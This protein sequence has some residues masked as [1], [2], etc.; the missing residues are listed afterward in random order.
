M[1]YFINFPE[2]INLANEKLTNFVRHKDP[3]SI[4]IKNS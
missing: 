1:I 3:N 2:F 4:Y